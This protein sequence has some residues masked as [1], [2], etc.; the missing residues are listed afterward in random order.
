MNVHNQPVLPLE[1]EWFFPIWGSP[2]EVDY[3]TFNSMQELEAIVNINLTLF[4]IIAGEVENA[5]LEGI[6]EIDENNTI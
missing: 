1:F 6:R 5:V 3:R 4:R 2:T